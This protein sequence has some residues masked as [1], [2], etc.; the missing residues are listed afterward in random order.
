V[1]LSK[2]AL[3]QVAAG[4]VRLGRGRAWRRAL[5]GA[6]LLALGALAVL[7]VSR[8][9]RT[10]RLQARIFA[11]LA[12]RAGYQIGE[13]PSGSIRFPP[14][15]PYDERLGY[16][17]IPDFLG[18]LERS[19]YRVVEQSRFTP[20]LVRLSRWGISPPYVEKGQPGLRI[21][22]WRG[23]SL[24]AVRFPRQG[25]VGF[26]DVPLLVTRSLLFIENRELL[27]PTHPPTANPALEWDR[28]GRALLAYGARAVGRDPGAV[29]GG[30]TLATQ[31]EKLRHSR[32]GITESP[33]EK[34]RQI[35]SASL[36]AYQ[37]G[38]DTTWLRRRVVV[39]YLNS[40]PL[41]A[42][43]GR[44]EVIGLADGLEA[45]YGLPF[46]R[47]NEVL[48]D[49]AAADADRAGLTE[50]GAVYRRVLSLLLAARRPSDYLIEAP[51]SLARRT[52]SYLRLLERHGVISPALRD[53]ALAVQE[54]PAARALPSRD[55][56]AVINRKVVDAARLPLVSL[57]GLDGFY[58]LDRLDLA[59]DSPLDVVAQRAVAREL[60]SLR[61]PAGAARAGL[62]GEHLLGGS[63]EPADGVV[64]SFALYER[65]RGANFL[66]VET[67]S[68][69]QRLSVN[70][71]AKLDLG[72]TAKLR[73]LVTY[74]E[75]IAQ[76]HDE[77]AGQSPE[78]LGRIPV[79]PADR[80]TAWVVEQL[81][82][83][84][85]LSLAELL[86]A[87]ME[88]RYSASPSEGFFTGGGV[89]RFRNFDPEDD[90]RVM[91]VR[92]G[93]RRSVNLVFIRLMRDVVTWYRYRLP[94]GK[95]AVLDDP[96]DPRRA[97][98]LR[99][100]ADRESRVFL[101]RF[102]REHL[103]LAPEQS[104]E[105]MLSGLRRV[106]PR[107]LAVLLR[108]L[109]PDLSL[110][111]FEAEMR[112]RLPGTRL[113]GEDFA[114]LYRAYRPGR[115]D[116]MDLGYLSGVHPLEIW[117]ARHLREHPRATLAE[118]IEASAGP[119]LEV[120]RWLYRSNR[121]HAQD[122]RIRTLLEIEAFQEIQRQWARCGYPFERLVPSYATAIGSSADRPSALA[123]LLGIVVAEGMR[124]PTVRL[125]RLVFAEQTPYETR[126]TPELNPPQRAMRA[127]VAAEVRAAL[128]DVVEQGT[129]RRVRQALREADGRVREVG[130]KTGTGDSLP[131]AG[132]AP[133]AAA[134]A[135]LID[136]HYYGVVTAWVPAAQARRY[137][138]TSSLPLQI[139]R[140]VAP[141]ALAALERVEDEPP[142]ELS[143]EREPAVAHVAAPRAG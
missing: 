132:G 40:L 59:V 81:R 115:F 73:T 3:Q 64:Y 57:L 22:D 136:D 127:E 63:G 122:V 50:R 106:T 21:S 113:D 104:L 33:L 34:V 43:A 70:E 49:D 60:W 62:Y 85:A 35:L 110:P 51:A 24:Y 52:D 119:R 54:T 41:A 47:A 79:A 95:A 74:L 137:G 38:A 5:L 121:R 20:A 97:V 99:E 96:S 84:P 44:G 112:G 78:A 28:L 48:R 58:E 65:G 19:H 103:G 11:A 32:G 77:L 102:F 111:R 68:F 75:L 92:E 98:Y 86:S 31:L 141:R 140:W 128:V 29:P 120:Y 135:F 101:T 14:A 9:L 17:R 105:V 10:S 118:A 88:R 25:Y 142:L 26:E 13:G 27:D 6:A 134:F 4:P 46:E 129:A 130:G 53:A 15:G 2:Q 90:A 89:H 91:T 93:F 45:W 39:D 126:L 80:L 124:Q 56:A 131:D 61:D 108:T 83:R 42:V 1:T 125:Q 66:R 71:G 69:D 76:L 107:R 94:D 36:R 133:R 116:L 55:D 12:A 82:A 23:Q 117:V 7:G 87:A 114:N 18:R 67:D 30:S 8:E 100:F 72:S 37:T 109:E 123:E 16:S 139:F 143:P 138:F